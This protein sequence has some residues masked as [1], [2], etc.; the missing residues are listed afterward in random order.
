MG[1][2]VFYA[3]Q[4][5]LNQALVSGGVPYGRRLS[6]SPG[7][8]ILRLRISIPAICTISALILLQLTF[9]FLLAFYAS[10]PTWTR[11]LDSFAV[12]RMGASIAEEVPLISS[13][14]PTKAGYCWTRR[15]A[16][17]APC[18]MSLRKRMVHLQLVGK[19]WWIRRL[20]TDST[21]PTRHTTKTS[22]RLVILRA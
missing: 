12:L 10:K 8:P 3:N 13:L 17:L 19:Q 21:K 7:Y 14:E 6:T 16:G 15:R 4:V 11:S 2:S 18:R 5:I 22:T 20:H 1:A 9:L